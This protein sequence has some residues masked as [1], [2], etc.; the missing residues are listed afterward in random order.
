MQSRAS[1]GTPVVPLSRPE[2]SGGKT[3]NWIT[4]GCPLGVSLV[5]ALY[6][7]SAVV[8][9]ILAVLGAA[10]LP[11]S[12]AL[13]AAVVP[14]GLLIL[15]SC[16]RA[17]FNWA[18]FG[19]IAVQVL[20]I[21]GTLPSLARWLPSA[22]GPLLN[23]IGGPISLRLGA[24]VLSPMGHLPQILMPFW[25]SATRYE[26]YQLVPPL[27]LLLSVIFLIILLSSAAREHCRSRSRS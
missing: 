5:V 6:D 22:F 7:I 23:G 26:I 8:S 12:M 14:L 1:E 9:L 3:R 19:L 25:P 20:C 16:L 17:G 15:A 27:T 21:M 11:W 10:V 4:G 24:L 18:R 13:T 2:L